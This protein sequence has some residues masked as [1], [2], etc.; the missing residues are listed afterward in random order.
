[1]LPPSDVDFSPRM[2]AARV[3]SGMPVEAAPSYAPPEVNS[4]P[5]AFRRRQGAAWRGSAPYPMEVMPP[6]AILVP[7][8]VQFHPY[9]KVRATRIPRALAHPLPAD[10]CMRP[11]H[12][13]WVVV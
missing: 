13:E 11:G 12:C 5:A 1:M 9:P 4:T 8:H 7:G 3:L 2:L 6:G 10:F